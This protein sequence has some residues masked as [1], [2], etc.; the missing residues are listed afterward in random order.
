MRASERKTTAAETTAV[1]M[2]GRADTQAHHDHSLPTIEQL[3]SAD[4]FEV[5]VVSYVAAIPHPRLPMSDFFK[6][7][8][9]CR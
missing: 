1:L 5:L 6:S 4:R 2:S 8:Y 7:S 3:A 9:R